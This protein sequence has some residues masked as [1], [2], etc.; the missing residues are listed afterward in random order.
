MLIITVKVIVLFTLTQDK[1]PWPVSAVQLPCCESKD[2]EMNFHGEI[3]GQ[4]TESALDTGQAL[5][6]RD[7]AGHLFC[8][9]SGWKFG[10]HKRT[11]NRIFIYLFWVLRTDSWFCTGGLFLVGLRDHIGYGNQAW[12]GSVQGKCPPCCP[13][14][15]ALVIVYL[16][17]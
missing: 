14:I 3:W 7:K 13:I 10:C 12:F 6:C 11:L 5:L 9:H 16:R 2:S 8:R 17:I 15:P 1:P 4:G